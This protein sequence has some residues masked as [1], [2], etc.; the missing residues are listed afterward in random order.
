MRARGSAFSSN[1]SAQVRSWSCPGVSIKAQGLPKASTSA[2]ILVV[3]PPRDRPIACSPFFLVSGHD[4]GV[5]HHVFVV[6][7]ACQQLE[8]ALENS[9]FRPPAEALVDDLPIAETLGKI[10]P[11]NAGSIS[12]E[13]GLDEQS[14][15]RRRAPDMALAA[16][17]KILDPIPLVVA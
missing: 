3:S 5:D 9:A 2:W 10:A 6:V 16:G 14:V 15:I 8:N 13:N 4:G 17:Q 12:V 7:I 11:R 1:G